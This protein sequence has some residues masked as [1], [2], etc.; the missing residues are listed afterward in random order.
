MRR[1]ITTARASRLT[2][3]RTPC[4]RGSARDCH[5]NNNYNLI[6]N[7]LR[8]VPPEG[9]QQCD[10]AGEPH[11]GG[12]PDYLR[13]LPRYHALDRRQIRSLAHRFPLTG[14][15]TVPPRVCTDCHINNNY[16]LNSTLCYSCHQKDYAGTNESSACGGGFPD[17]LRA[18]P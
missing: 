17:D 15:H 14:A 10:H 13:K 9:L 18:L 4:R 11:H 7:G 3:N 8:L 1:S 6:D 5:V 12:L 2:G 16:T